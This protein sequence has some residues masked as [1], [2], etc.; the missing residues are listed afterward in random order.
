[1]AI[2]NLKTNLNIDKDN[3]INRFKNKDAYALWKGE[4]VAKYQNI[5]KAVYKKL[6]SLINTP[7]LNDLYLIPGNKKHCHTGVQF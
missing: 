4:W 3:K 6:H 1:M 2:Q 5:K 7:N